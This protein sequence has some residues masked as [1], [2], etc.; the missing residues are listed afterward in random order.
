[1]NVSLL[2]RSLLNYRCH[3]CCFFYAGRLDETERGSGRS[4][5]LTRLRRNYRLTIRRCFRDKE[6]VKKD[7]N[8][9]NK[10]SRCDSHAISNNEIHAFA[11]AP[12][13]EFRRVARLSADDLE[14]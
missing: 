3:Y 7:N 2:S 14:S 11:S 9:N 13:L 10:C 1:M 8:N 5:P 6:D 4:E 12:S